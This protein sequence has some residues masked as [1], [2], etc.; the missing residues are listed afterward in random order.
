MSPGGGG[1]GPVPVG[2]GAQPGESRHRLRPA[3]IQITIQVPPQV[4][5]IGRLRPDGAGRAGI[6]GVGGPHQNHPPPGDGEHYPPVP[7]FR[8]HQRPLRRPQVLRPVQQ[9]RPFGQA[10]PR[11]GL[12][13]GQRGRVK[14]PSGGD[15]AAGQRFKTPLLVPQSHPEPLPVGRNL[16]GGHPGNG[17]RPVPQHRRFQ[18]ADGQPGVVGL[19]VPVNKTAPQPLP[20]QRGKHFQRLPGPQPAPPGRPPPPAQQ[21]VQPQP[22]PQH[23]GQGRAERSPAGKVGQ[24]RPP[25]Q[26]NDEFQIRIKKVGGAPQDG[27]LPQAFPYQPEPEMGK[28]ADPPVQQFGGFAG[29]P[30]SEVRPFHQGDPQSPPGRVPGHGG[31][32]DPA[33][34]HQQIPAAPVRQFPAGP[35]PG[36]RGG[37]SPRIGGGGA[38]RHPPQIIGKRPRN[39]KPNA[40]TRRGLPAPGRVT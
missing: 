2:Q 14:S 1:G 31:A 35:L 7:G 20:A 12:L 36:P 39:R 26:R 15:Y 18:H 33:P 27:L 9:M 16:L 32:D 3:R 13:P 21:V 37:G 34:R 38:G 40:G 23:R 5:N 11:P 17:R 28:V 30:R 10:P 29:R 25:E 4:L 22:G 24:T 19:G 8:Q 6:G